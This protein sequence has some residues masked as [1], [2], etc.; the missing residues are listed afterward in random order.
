[1]L[2]IKDVFEYNKE[3]KGER[4]IWQIHRRFMLALILD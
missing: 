2:A 4:F 1:M 3:K